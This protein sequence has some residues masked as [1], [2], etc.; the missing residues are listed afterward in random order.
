MT[1]R[2]PMIW[3]DDALVPAEA[4]RV[5]AL[6]HGLTVGDGVFETLK[7]VDGTPF[8]LTRHLAR[9]RRSAAGLRLE[10]GRD[11]A[12]L[13]AAVAAVLAANEVDRGRLRITVTGGPGPLGSDRGPN[14]STLVVASAPL[15]E[16][17]P[18][19]DVVTVPWRRNEHGAL[20]GLKTTSYGENVVALAEARRQGADEAVLA[21]TAG[22]LCE[23]TGSN[24]FLVLDGA[25]ITPTLA[26]GCLPGVTRELVLEQL[27]DIEPLD[28]PLHRLA[29]ADEAFLT[30]STRDVQPIRTVDGV[31]LPA[32]PGPWT[33]RAVEALRALEASTPDP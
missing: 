32:C 33:R 19:S 9:L 14:G 17:A 10:V 4:A 24:V 11:D 25:P 3:L 18:S 21:N 6:D 12:E 22:E 30:S 23:G 31:V 20:T 28:L 7:V 26:A 15:P 27:P 16:P 5:S 29:D 13:R 1:T 8:A 2:H